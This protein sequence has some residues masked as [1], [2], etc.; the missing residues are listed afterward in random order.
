MR[1]LRA[2][3]IFLL[4]F[5]SFP[6]NSFA[7][8][9]NFLGQNH[10]Y[11]VVLRG[12]GEAIISMKAVV[13]NLG[14]DPISNIKLKLPGSVNAQDLVAYQIIATPRCVQYDYTQK[15]DPTISVIAPYPYPCLSYQDET[16][17]S[18][19]YVYDANTKYQKAQ[20]ETNNNEINISLPKPIAKEKSGAY[21]LYFR[22]MGM[23]AKQT[24]GIFN[25]TFE[26]IKVEDKI[27]SLQVGISTDSDLYLKNAT[28]QVDYKNVSAPVAELNGVAADA[29]VT[30]RSFDNFY[31]QIGYGSIQKSASNLASGESYKVTGKYADTKWKLYIN[32]ILIGLGV[33]ALVVFLIVIASISIFKF[34]HSKQSPSSFSSNKKAAIVIAVSFMQSLSIGILTIVLVFAFNFVGKLPFSYMGG[35]I[36]ISIILIMCMLVISFML[37]AGILFGPVLV[38]GQKYGITWAL[39]TFFLSIVWIVLFAIIFTVGYFLI[40]GNQNQIYPMYSRGVTEPAIAPVQDLKTIN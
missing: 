36:S 3:V 11:S 27:Q 38:I 22:S 32:E 14:T 26:S 21:F 10:K 6:I 17:D 16:Y 9:P 29:Q 30:S 4:L 33:L 12:N 5:L 20:V 24:G 2:F 28:G 13:S 31:N 1:F 39:F 40:V 18:Y 35:G 7:Q 25:Y 37:Y 23:V 15:S 34:S 19:S 8:A